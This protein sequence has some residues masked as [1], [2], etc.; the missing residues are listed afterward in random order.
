[1]AHWRSSSFSPYLSLG[2][3]LRMWMMLWRREGA[4]GSELSSLHSPGLTK[5]L[6][7]KGVLPNN[8]LTP[9]STFPCCRW[10]LTATSSRLPTLKCSRASFASIVAH[11]FSIS[12]SQCPLSFHATVCHLIEVLNGGR[13]LRVA[14]N[15]L[16]QYP[17]R[18]HTQPWPRRSNHAATI[19]LVL[20]LRH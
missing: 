18:C 5:Q 11:R 13:F 1:M 16:T 3:R 4:T 12:P 9:R 6:G 15:R 14:C 7:S 2:Y 10:M 20:A 19:H 17:S 8:D